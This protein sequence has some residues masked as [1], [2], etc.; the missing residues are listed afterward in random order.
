MPSVS[1][2]MRT[3]CV[4][5][6][7]ILLSACSG[8]IQDQV[9]GGNALLGEARIGAL[10]TTASYR[11][12]IA[13]F[14]SDAKV[15]PEPPPDVAVAVTQALTAGLTIPGKGPDAV[16]KADLSR[17]VAENITPLL[18]RTAAVQFYRDARSYNC[19]AHMNGALSTEEYITANN[20]ALRAAEFL[21][22]E[23][24]KAGFTPIEPEQIITKLEEITKAVK[25]LQPPKED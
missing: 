19:F 11:T 12:V 24:I 2:Y 16:A 23:E 3:A 4:G 1:G 10:S 7:A 15:C 9:V 20:D 17:A 13:Q 22:K 8:G 21:L 14:D 18:R 6:I 5:G 25:D